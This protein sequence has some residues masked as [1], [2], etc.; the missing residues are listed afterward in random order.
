MTS[1]KSLLMQLLFYHMRSFTGDEI[2]SKKMKTLRW[3]HV[4]ESFESVNGHCLTICCWADSAAKVNYASGFAAS[5]AQRLSSGSN[6][7]FEIQHVKCWI[8]KV[9][10]CL[11]LILNFV[12]NSRIKV[13]T[14]L[15]MTTAY[16]ESSFYC[17]RKYEYFKGDAKI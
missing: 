9:T 14:L 15:T 11:K 13:Q 4:Y 10:L 8:K 5:C 7:K 17:H 2:I 3:H 1:Y 12:H 6:V 16:F